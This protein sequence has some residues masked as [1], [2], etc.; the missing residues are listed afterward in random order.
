MTQSTPYHKCRENARTESRSLPFR[1]VFVLTNLCNLR[2]DFCFQE[3]Q[4]KHGSLTSGDWIEIIKK[5]PSGSHITLTGGEPLLFN[6]FEQIVKSIPPSITFNVITNGLLLNKNLCKLL[7]SSESFRVLSVSVDDIG[8]KSR[9]FSDSQWNLLLDNLSLYQQLRENY[10]ERGEK[11]ILDIKT[12]IH[13]GNSA[14]LLD[15]ALFF[16]AMQVDTHMFMFLKGSEIQH[17]D[18]TFDFSDIFKQPKFTPQY[19]M[20]IV[21]DQILLIKSFA[22]LPSVKTRFFLHPEIHDLYSS[23]PVPKLSL[24]I[25]VDK[26]YPERYKPCRAPWESM[27]INNDGNVFPCLA[28]CAGNIKDS[29]LQDVVGSANIVSFKEHLLRSGTV[30]ACKQCGYLKPI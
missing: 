3:K 28:F 29:A 13:A 14:S 30:P 5:L 2:C 19:D 18:L 12:V 25:D 23:S 15:I 21:Q 8:N 7:L 22:N 27:H 11:P 6:G 10:S 20:S 4:Y 9:D 16:S 24:F 26:H 1:Y 17:S